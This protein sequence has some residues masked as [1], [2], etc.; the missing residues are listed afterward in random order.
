MGASIPGR[1]TRSTG[2]SRDAMSR[3]RAMSSPEGAAGSAFGV[4]Y[5]LWR[6]IT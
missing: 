3:I 6:A 5:G 1:P 2:R 4:V